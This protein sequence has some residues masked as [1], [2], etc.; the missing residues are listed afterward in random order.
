MVV[1]YRLFIVIIALSLTMWPQFAVE[2][3]R[4]SNQ[5]GVGRFEQSFGRKG[6]TDVMSCHVKSSYVM[7]CHVET[8]ILK[9]GEVVG[10]QR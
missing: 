7:S 10:G 9:D 1:S 8:C 3:I 4:R 2:C 6:S 5:Q